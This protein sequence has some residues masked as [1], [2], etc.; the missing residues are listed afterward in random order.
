MKNGGRWRFV[1]IGFVMM[2][3]LGFLDSWSVFVLP[4]EQEFGWRRDQTSLAYSLAMVFFSSGIL[5]GGPMV[6]HN[7]PRVTTAAAGGILCTGF[8]AI[9]RLTGLMELYM[10][11]GLLC[12]LAIGMLYNCIIAT[13][14][15]WFPNNRGLVTG[16]LMVGT[17]VGS[18]IIG[19]WVAPLFQTISWRTVFQM[20]GIAAAVLVVGVGQ[21]LRSAVSPETGSREKAVQKT[22][23]RREYTWREVLHS[24]AFWRL[25]LWHLFIIAGGQAALGHIVPFGVEQGIGPNSAAIAMGILAVS[26]ASGRI[27][28]GYLADK[29]GRKAAMLLASVTM[30]IAMLS[31][32][33]AVPRFGFQGLALSAVLIGVGYGG[34][35]P[36]VS[37]V[38]GDYFGAKYFGANFGLA[39]TG[40]AVAA[41]IGP[42]LSGCIKAFGGGYETGFFLLAAFAFA[43]TIVILPIE[44]PQAVVETADSPY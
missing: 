44:A 32:A 6:D 22:V 10:A 13:V 15:R 30:T 27:L 35:I 21:L 2:L 17:G 24:K 14:V 18:L 28:F 40:I 11:Y 20:L 25:W 3:V 5:I 7:G 39:S 37:A 4:M 23:E 43:S 34:T 42:Y 8:F 16:L 29:S 33:T 9:S 36:Q 38:V 12:G 19:V 26:N 1:L 31:L 41:L